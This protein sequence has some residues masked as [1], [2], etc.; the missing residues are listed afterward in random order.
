MRKTLTLEK[1][2]TKEITSRVNVPRAE[3]KNCYDKNKE[4]FNLPEGYHL[5]HI[6]VTPFPGQR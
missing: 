6:M 5:Q 2:I 3:I 1:L 4:S